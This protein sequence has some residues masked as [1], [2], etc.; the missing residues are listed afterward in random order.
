[1]RLD[2][3]QEPHPSTFTPALRSLVCSPSR[4]LV[5]ID[6]CQATPN[7]AQSLWSQSFTGSLDRR[8]GSS[9]LHCNRGEREEEEGKLAAVQIKAQFD[10]SLELKGKGQLALA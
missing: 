2:H 5:S 8:A 3:G 1:M 10:Q 7:A 6:I 9:G 4:L